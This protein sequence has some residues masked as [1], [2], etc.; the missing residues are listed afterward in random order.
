MVTL[1]ESTTS[2]MIGEYAM[3]DYP[4]RLLISEEEIRD[5]VKVISKELNARYEEL[6]IVMIM[7]GAICFVA[8]LIRNLHVKV[9]L[10]Y[11]Q[12]TSYYGGTSRSELKVIGTDNIDI[13]GKN[14]LI[15]DD[16]YDSGVTLATVYDKLLAKKPKTLQSMVLLTKQVEHSTEYKPDY[17]MFN[18]E[19]EFVVGY[20]LDY[21]EYYRGLPGI[22]V[23]EVN[24]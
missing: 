3:S 12:C 6:V 22:F 7:K 24:D 11:I 10:E 1:E 20:G 16:I 4:L 9:A 19:N 2:T 15:V 17:S 18:I 14:V 8:D 21:E 5:K 13:E 23:M